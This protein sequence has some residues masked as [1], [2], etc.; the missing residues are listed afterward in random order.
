VTTTPRYQQ[1]KEQIIRQISTGELRPLDRVPSENQ[2]VGSAGV[3][4]MTANRAL[5]ELNDEGY[6]ERVAGKGT[7]VA[8]L[9]ATSHVLEVRNIADEIQ[10]RGHRHSAAVIT[11]S[12]IAAG[13]EVAAMLQLADGDDVF[14]I[15]LIHMENGT[16]IQLEDRYV[17]AGFAPRCLGQDFARITPSAYLSSISPLQEA[18]HIVRAELPTAEVRVQ[19]GMQDPEPCLVVIRRTWAHGQAVSYAH[20]HHPGSRY[21][22]T[23]H[24]AP[25]GT[26]KS[27]NKPA[28][29]A[30][31]EN[32]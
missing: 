7:F 30:R 4:R 17:S 22:L 2:L 5:R 25:P 11:C 24:Y 19:L 21:E 10:H 14:H 23:G 1:L 9:K 20:L 8:D 28:L 26:R 29:T 3:S 18:E 13:A 27:T 32:C 12:L 31:Q 16:P 15:V 6:V